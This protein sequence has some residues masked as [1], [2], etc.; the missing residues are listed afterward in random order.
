MHVMHVSFFLDNSRN[1]HVVFQMILMKDVQY[2]EEN[3]VVYRQRLTSFVKIVR[4]LNFYYRRT[5][6]NEPRTHHEQQAPKWRV[7]SDALEHTF[8]I[9]EVPQ[10]TVAAEIDCLDETQMMDDYQDYTTSSHHSSNQHFSLSVGSKQHRS[11]SSVGS[12]QQSSQSSVGSKQHSSQSSVGS[13]QHNSQSLVGSKQSSLSQP[14]KS[15][16]PGKHTFNNK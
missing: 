7:A 13:K 14:R 3:E 11:Q 8:V 5:S 9:K 16:S 10:R 15:G 2:I 4:A 6:D 12:K 1:V